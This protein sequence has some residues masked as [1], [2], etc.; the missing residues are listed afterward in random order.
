MPQVP[1]WV[2]DAV[3]YQIFPERFANADPTNDPPGAL[4]WGSAGPTRE[5]FFGGDLQGVIDHLDHIADLGANALYL[6]PIFDAETNHRYD[7]VDYERID[8]HLGDLPTFRRL[9]AQAHAR[10]IRIVLD[11]VFNHCGQGH[12]A[13]A[14]V[15]ARGA[16]SPYQN[17]FY[18]EDF[19]VR[20]DPEGFNYSTC[21]G[22]Y[23][24][25]QWNVH[26]AEVRAHLF[27]VTRRWTAE[28]I[29]G[30]RLDVPYFMNRNFWRRFREL[31]K[32]IDDSLYIVAEY[33]E[34]ATE[35]V[36]GDLADGAMNYPLRDLILALAADGKLSPSAFVDGVATLYRELPVPAHPGMLNVLGSHDT[37][38]LL[39][40]CGGDRDRLRQAV[41][42]LVTSPGAPMIY[43]GDEVGLIGENDPGCRACMPWDQ[44]T[45]DQEILDWTR[46]MLRL[47]REHPSLSRGS[48]SLEA[49]GSVVVRRRTF[50]G[51]EVLLAVNVGDTT[52]TLTPPSGTWY[53][54]IEGSLCDGL[55]L[56]PPHGVTVLVGEGA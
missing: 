9:V 37:E 51:D 5:N 6:T 20:V 56:V 44:G 42:L 49:V 48:D 12:W 41:A 34:T 29:D 36:R 10:G 47:R 25:P 18:V 52:A 26:N 13:F 16:E 3:F 11:A 27:D 24:L 17:W 33:W 43:Y 50:V 40:R 23:Y 55:V 7:C 30:W 22:A 4:P 8:P 35:W 54:W 19:P 38:R 21:G 39:T 2:Q 32:G 15:V 45:W 53:D 14:D 46:A 28:G 31:V 1:D